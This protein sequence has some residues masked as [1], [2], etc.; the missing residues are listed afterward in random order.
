MSETMTIDE[1]HEKYVDQWLLVN[2]PVTDEQ[3]RVQSG[4]VVFASKDREET[5]R[6]AMKRTS[7]EIA[8]VFTGSM[9]PDIAYV[10]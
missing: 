5:Y 2:D 10:L 4:T 9:S 1:M 7:R 8:F 3:S 6:A